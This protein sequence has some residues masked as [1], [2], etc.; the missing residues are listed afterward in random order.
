MDKNSTCWLEEPLEN[1]TEKLR[2]IF[3]TRHSS[4]ITY[5]FVI[6]V[7]F[8]GAFV[9]SSPPRPL[10]AHAASYLLS[11][12][13]VCLSLLYLSLILLFSPVSHSP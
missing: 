10:L 13:F 6:Y 9:F 2:L 11:Y 3:A 5:F 8:Q 7:N 12:P 4:P 1:V